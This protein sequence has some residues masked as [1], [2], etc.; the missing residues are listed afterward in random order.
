MNSS[1]DSSANSDLHQYCF[2]LILYLKKQMNSPE[3]N[4]EIT[5]DAASQCLS[6][7]LKELYPNF[8]DLG[9]LQRE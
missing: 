5:V 1:L 7:F 3:D 6:Y 4:D 8:G 9:S 2:Y